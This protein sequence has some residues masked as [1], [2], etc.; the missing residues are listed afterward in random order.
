MRLIVDMNL[1]PAWV[2]FLAASGFEASHWSQLGAPAAADV[3][4]MAYARSVGAVILSTNS[5]RIPLM[6]SSRTK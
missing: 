6:P 3:E 5:R 2:E 4:I 1:S